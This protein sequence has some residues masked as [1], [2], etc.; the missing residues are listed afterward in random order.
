MLKQIFDKDILLFLLVNIFVDV[1]ILT[2]LLF[3]PFDFIETQ[4]GEISFIFIPIVILMLVLSHC[5]ILPVFYSEMEKLSD[6]VILK[7]F[8]AN[9]KKKFTYKFVVLI[10]TLIYPLIFQN[11]KIEELIFNFGNI[12]LSIIF[13]GAFGS[14]VALFVY[15]YIQDHFSK[16]NIISKMLNLLVNKY[17]FIFSISFIALCYLFLIMSLFIKQITLVLAVLFI[18]LCFITSLLYFINKNK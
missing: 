7:K 8:I 14:Y 3:L 12:F 4:I 2:M 13:M 10:I 18:A 1:S 17:T 16:Y 11:I 15:W 6:N 5:F 9:L